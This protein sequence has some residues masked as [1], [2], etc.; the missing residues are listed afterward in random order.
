MGIAFTVDSVL[1]DVMCFLVGRLNVQTALSVLVDGIAA[2]VLRTFAGHAGFTLQA[3][4]FCL[5]G[6]VCGRGCLLAVEFFALNPGALFAEDLLFDIAIHTA[7]EVIDLAV[8][9]T[10]LRARVVKFALAEAGRLVALGFMV[11]AQDF[12]I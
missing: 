12:V 3:Q 7:P 1:H 6:V 11:G 8:C 2:Q 5:R 9:L 10:V 4:V